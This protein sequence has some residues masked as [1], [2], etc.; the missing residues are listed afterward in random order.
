MSTSTTSSTATSGLTTAT[1]SSTTAAAAASRYGMGMS[2]A[3]LGLMMLATQNTGG[4]RLGPHERST[5]PE[6]RTRQP[7]TSAATTKRRSANRPGGLAA[8]Y[9]N[10]DR[11]RSPIS[12]KL[13]Q[14]AESLLPV[15]CPIE[16]IPP[17]FDLSKRA[18]VPIVS[19]VKTDPAPDAGRLSSDREPKRRRTGRVPGERDRPE[20]S[21]AGGVGSPARV[22]VRPMSECREDVSDGS[23]K[24]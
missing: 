6:R 20:S 1:S 13:L 4:S 8:R 22:P 12:P 11:P 3:Q 16:T 9:F 23:H 17:V 19:L 7:P 24:E 10:R 15:S 2:T 18:I 21:P 14:P 5:A